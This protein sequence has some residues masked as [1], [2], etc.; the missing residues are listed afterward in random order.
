MRLRH[1]QDRLRAHIRARIDRGEMTGA[2]LSRKAGFQQGH[3]SNFL[4]SRR[5]LSLESMDRLLQTLRI[6]VLDLVDPED[7]QRRAII[8]DG[9]AGAENVVVVSAERAARLA[10]FAPQQV[11]GTI[12]FS[13][14]F[15]RRLRPNDVGNRSDWLRFVLIRLSP[16]AARAVVPR[17]RVSAI[18]LIDRHYNSLEPYRRL[19]P[20]LYA[21]RINGGCAIGSVSLAGDH[22]VLQPRNSQFPVEA[23]RIER[24]R[25]YSDYIVGRVCH[26]AVEV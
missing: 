13:T 4:N 8:P 3:L 2:G 5:G 11:E 14:S 22:L 7:I 12:R 24:S 25:S 1:L 26:V 9:S 21:V 15:L 19:Q 20:N 10:R 18:V 16:S 23:V 6:S 17:T